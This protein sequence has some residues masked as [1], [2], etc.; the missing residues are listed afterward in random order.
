MT[1]DGLGG[2]A[3][4]AELFTVDQLAELSQNPDPV[5]Y[6]LAGDQAAL[7]PEMKKGGI[8]TKNQMIAFLANICQETD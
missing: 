1:T 5:R 4:A 3:D 6:D 2:G 8:V 7:V